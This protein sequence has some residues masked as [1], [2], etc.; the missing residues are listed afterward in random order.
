V[1]VNALVQRPLYFFGRALDAM[2]RGPRV[3]L[4]ATAT[5]FVAVLVTGLF[6]AVVHG[7]GR[8]LAGFAGEVQISVYLDQEADLEAARVAAAAI[9]PGRKVE[10]VSSAEALRRFRASLGSQGALLDGVGEEVLPPSVEVHAPGIHLAEARALAA[11]LRALPGV[12]EV[13]F[14]NEWLERLERLLERLRQV[15]T[16]LLVALTLG[17]AVLVANTLRLSVLARRDEI[18]IM[19]LVG[20]TD[21]FVETPFFIEG[22]LQGLFGGSLAALALLLVAVLGLPRLEHALGVAIPLPL[23]E[24]LPAPLLL[25]LALGGGALGLTASALA[26]RRERRRGS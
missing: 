26:V 17:A 13:D 7:A 21:A 2:A 12:R 4:V 18:E 24:L 20:A 15:G 16:A 19:K 9:A 3:T 25:G 8:L 5:I 1:S 22:L 14:G 23:R 11:R 10:A 6:A